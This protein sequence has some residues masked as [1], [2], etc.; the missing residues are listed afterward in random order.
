MTESLNVLA[1][2]IKAVRHPPLESDDERNRVRRLIEQSAKIISASVN[3]EDGPLY[4]RMVEI[5]GVVRDP[6][7]VNESFAWLI[8]PRPADPDAR[9]RDIWPIAFLLLLCLK[10]ETTLADQIKTVITKIYKESSR[11]ISIHELNVRVELT[12]ELCDDYAI[13]ERFDASDYLL[14]M[15]SETSPLV[16][17]TRL[18]KWDDKECRISELQERFLRA[19]LLTAQEP[20]TGKELQAETDCSNTTNT[21]SR[22]RKKLRDAGFDLQIRTFGQP[23][24]YQYVGPILCVPPT[25]STDSNL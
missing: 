4:R 1:T 11:S 5:S 15:L 19:F 10:A 18:V 7:R 8:Y 20:R 17:E 21:L 6:K 3:N 14:R 12:Y 22:I 25:D 13:L 23:V 9:R 24:T 2:L 16:I